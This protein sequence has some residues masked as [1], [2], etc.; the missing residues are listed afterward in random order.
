MTIKY[1]FQGMLKRYVVFGLKYSLLGALNGANAHN[2]GIKKGGGGLIV[3]CN[4]F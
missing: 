3:R 4:S 1:N 2:T